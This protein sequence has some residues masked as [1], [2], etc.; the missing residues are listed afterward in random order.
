MEF[1]TKAGAETAL[2]KKDN[3]SFAGKA[4]EKVMTREGWLEDRNLKV[5][6]KKAE[7]DAK[8]AKDHEEAEKK[9]MDEAMQQVRW[10]SAFGPQA[11]ANLKCFVCAV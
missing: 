10:R 6:A 1:H 4:I 8:K 9:A 2:A 3:L 7:R 5:K 11:A